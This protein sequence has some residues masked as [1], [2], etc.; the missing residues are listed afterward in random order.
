MLGRI[1]ENSSVFPVLL[2]TVTF[3]AVGLRLMRIGVLKI[4]RKARKL[5]PV[6]RVVCLI[7]HLYDKYSPTTNA[8]GTA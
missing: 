1:G 4:A 8:A 2:L 7:N 5:I 6:G 3:I